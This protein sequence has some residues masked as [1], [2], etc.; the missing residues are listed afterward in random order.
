MWMVIS[1]THDNMENTRKA[2]ELAKSRN[3][4]TIFHCGDI[5][6]PFTAKL[7]KVFNGKI[8]VVSGNNDGEKVML[9][10]ILGDT[11]FTSPTV[12]IH[13]E[14]RIA[15]MHEPFGLERL[16]DLDYIFYGHT[17]VIDIRPGDVFIANPGEACGYLSGKGTC[18]LLNELTNG[19]EILEL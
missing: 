1:D 12:I 18:I 4:D 8:F 7:F 9:K 13:Q 5:V 10:E 15:L 2:I 16:T 19:F 6:S 14:K 3:V 17:H 11:F